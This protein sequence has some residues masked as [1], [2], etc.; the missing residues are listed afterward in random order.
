[1][2]AISTQNI[3]AQ[4][5]FR[6]R[7]PARLPFFQYFRT[8]CAVKLADLLL[9]FTPYIVFYPADV[10]AVLCPG[11]CKS[12]SSLPSVLITKRNFARQQRSTPE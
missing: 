12:E 8:N 2:A 7:H 6:Q 1:M 9:A 4:F 5:V 11:G 10:L 3:Y